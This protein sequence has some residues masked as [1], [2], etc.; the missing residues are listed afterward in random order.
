ML[1]IPLIASMSVGL[2][3]PPEQNSGHACSN[4]SV[5]HH[6]EAKPLDLPLVSNRGTCGLA[7]QVHIVVDNELAVAQG[8]AIDAYVQSVFDYADS[9]WSRPV[10]QGGAGID[11]ILEGVTVF[12]VADPWITETDPLGLLFEFQTYTQAAIPLDGTTRDAVVL[13]TGVD[14]DNSN[15]TSAFIGTIGTGDAQ[16]L[17]QATP[18]FTTDFVGAG[19]AH[20]LGHSMSAFHDGQNNT[21]FVTDRIMSPGS[22]V[23]VAASNFSGCSHDYFEQFINGNPIVPVTLESPCQPCVADVNGD[24]ML[25]PTDF[26][27]WVGA[28]NANL[29]GCDQNNDGSCTPTDF[30]AWIGNYNAGC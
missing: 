21:C 25:S 2:P 30:T 26:T 4:C 20:V 7:I 28:F 13:L 8:A 23:N 22:Q 12:D 15:L 9:V 10:I 5:V 17:M 18:G 27:A 3:V 6:S 24:G 14:L 1:A 16:G 19:V 29:P 11:L